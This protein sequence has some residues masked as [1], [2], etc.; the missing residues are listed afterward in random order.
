MILSI[1]F[2]NLGETT[3]DK[4]CLAIYFC[5]GVIL[6]ENKCFGFTNSCRYFVITIGD[7]RTAF[8]LS[9]VVYIIR[10]GACQN[11]LFNIEIVRASIWMGKLIF[12]VYIYITGAL[13]I[14][15]FE[16]LNIMLNL[17]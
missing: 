6:V 3:R 2:D 16:A 7:T 1:T 11:E 17:E 4:S 15:S 12:T 10:K 8:D 13:G 5:F 14:M 9:K